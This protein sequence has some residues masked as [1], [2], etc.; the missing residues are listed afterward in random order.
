[1]KLFPKQW[2]YLKSHLSESSLLLP[3]IN[4]SQDISALTQTANIKVQKKFD[5]LKLNDEES[6]VNAL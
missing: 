6:K 2:N 1:M 4:F 3:E 5:M